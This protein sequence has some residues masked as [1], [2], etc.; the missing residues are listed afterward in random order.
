MALALRDGRSF[1]GQEIIIG[2]EDGSRLT[3]LAHAHPLRDDAGK[4]A[5][6]V[7]ILVDITERKLAFEASRRLAAI[8]ETSDD[9]I[10]SKSLDGTVRSWNQA[11]ERMFGW[12]AYE[13]IGRSIT[14]IIPPDR[15]AEETDVLQRIGRGETI[16]HYE[17]VRQRKDGKLLDISL[18]VSPLRD[19]DGTIIGASKIARDITEQKRIQ[20]LLREADRQKDEFLAMLAHELRNPLAPISNAVQLLKLED[21]DKTTME[22]ARMVI[23]RQ[24]HHMVRLVDDLMDVSRISQN[25]L[26]L[27]KERIELARAVQSA[28]EA[29]RPLLQAAGQHF[30]VS[31]PPEPVWLDADLTRLAQVFQNLLNNAAKYS[32]HGGRISLVARVENGQAVVSVRD[33]G[34]GIPREMLGQIF[35][36]FTQVDRTLERSQGG[37]GIGLS[38]VKRLV[39][40]HGG[41]VE[42]ISEGLRRGSEFIVRLPL[43][44]DRPEKA[45]T[46]GAV[47]R[48]GRTLGCRILVV[49]D[50]RD[51]ALT[52]GK[53]LE[54]RG[55]EVRTAHDGIEALEIAAT[56]RPEV[57]LLDIGLPRLNGYETAKR[58]RKEPWGEQMFLIAVTGWGQ[59][60]DRR[61]SA[62]AGFNLHLV[63]P[64]DHAALEGLLAGFDKQK[65]VGRITPG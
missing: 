60:E 41:T 35:E 50:N 31:L 52:L 15:H 19:R 8:V 33:D 56:F 3:V 59:D 47:T 44:A 62:E 20:K 58:I 61:R 1:E 6:A 17:T 38:L 16:H 57:A 14:L 55:N 39:A 49:D 34:V 46:S 9:A 26:V 11:A 22:R 2:R 21:N 30:H 40:M 25:K 48:L 42:A 65:S 54:L 12:R 29:V 5:G 45:G 10:V 7:N 36:M 43:L 51:S 4:I 18:S 37:L 23:E 63:K 13:A 32:E 53:M 24:L 27:R 28:V 64:L